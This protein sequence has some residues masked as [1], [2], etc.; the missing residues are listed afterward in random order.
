MQHKATV[1]LVTIHNLALLHENMYDEGS[2]APRI[3]LGITW[4]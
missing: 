1:K 4:V 3:N 2:V